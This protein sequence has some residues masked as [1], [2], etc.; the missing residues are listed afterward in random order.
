VRVTRRI[1]LLGGLAAFSLSV[2]RRPAAGAAVAP[3]AVL[4][5]FY[6]ALLAAMKQATSLGFEGR[7]RQL[8][9][10][11]EAAFNLPLMIRLAVGPQWNSLSPAQQSSLLD[12]FRR[13]T[14]ATYAS[15][16]D[17]YD[18]ER[19]EVT[20]E[21]PSPSG[22]ILVETRLVPTKGDVVELNYLL[23][24]GDT[25]W[26]IIDVFLSGT[27]SELATRRAEFTSVL[28]RDGPDGLVRLLESKLAALTPR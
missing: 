19:F 4:E 22:G 20:G 17:G 15:R 16:F 26:Q 3:R 2:G 13:F 10:A 27:I 6:A 23:R 28:S 21:A 12:V 18:G 9:P 5:T 14:I 8:R 7:E 1:A 11:I 25:G 24:Q